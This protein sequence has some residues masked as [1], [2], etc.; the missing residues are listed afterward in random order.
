MRT[1]FARSSTPRPLV[2]ARLRF[3][4][5]RSTWAWITALD[6]SREERQALSEA[7]SAIHG[8]FDA[9]RE[10]VIRGQPPVV[11]TPAVGSAIVA[12]NPAVQEFQDRWSETGRR[13]N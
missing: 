7:K 13:H 12:A 1:S 3:G 6:A 4:L 5:L 9:Q 8:A 2:A 10:R 11:L